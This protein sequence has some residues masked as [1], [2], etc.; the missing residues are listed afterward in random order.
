MLENDLEVR[1]TGMIMSALRASI[2][3]VDRDPD[4]T[5]GATTCWRFAP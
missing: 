4:L 3:F 2:A 1:R 5:V